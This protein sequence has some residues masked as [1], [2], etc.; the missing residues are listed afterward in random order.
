MTNEERIR[1]ATTEELAEEIYMINNISCY[2]C[3]YN[4]QN[5]VGLCR[6]GIM[7]WLESEVN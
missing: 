3:F 6:E 1:Q 5:C 2:G 7:K 4:A